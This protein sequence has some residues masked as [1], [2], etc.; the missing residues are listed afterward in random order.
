MAEEIG[1][2]DKSYATT[3]SK[4]VEQALVEIMAIRRE[5]R[6]MTAEDEEYSKSIICKS[7]IEVVKNHM[8]NVKTELLKVLFGHRLI[9]LVTR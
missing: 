8:S 9:I 5:L 2:C 3:I 6:Q 1:D 7:I 4:V